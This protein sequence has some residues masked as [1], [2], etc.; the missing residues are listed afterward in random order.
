MRDALD[1][2][3]L[4]FLAARDSIRARADRPQRVRL[5][6]QVCQIPDFRKTLTDA[7]L[8]LLATVFDHLSGPRG[9]LPS[10]WVGRMIGRLDQVDGDID[11]LV[12][13]IA[14]VRTWTYM[15]H[16]EGWL[17]DAGALAGPGARGRG[18]AVRRAA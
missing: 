8:H 12:N 10:D 1:D 18:P 3:S 5:L 13:R 2:R 6:W 9:V 15:A 7:H 14:H 4:A 17:E 11:A 16:R